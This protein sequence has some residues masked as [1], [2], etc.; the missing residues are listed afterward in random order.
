MASNP[1]M[2]LAPASKAPPR[3]LKFTQKGLAAIK[4]PSDPK[5]RLWV[6]DSEKPGLAFLVTGNGARSFYQYR[7]IHGKPTR[8]RLGGAELTI[9]QARGEVD[10]LN[11]EIIGGVDPME[12]RRQERTAGTIK[13]LWERYRDEHLKIRC[14]ARTLF[15][16]ENRYE[17]CLD[18]W[19]AR[20]VLDIAESDV[21]ALHARLGAERGHTTGNR[22]VQL[23]RR[24]FN[25]GR[26][27]NPAGK[28][29]VT[30]F[31]ERSRER[32]VQPDEL[33]RLFKALDDEQTNPLI[34]DFIY[35]AL[36]TGAR[37][38]AVASMRDEEINLP[39]RTWTIPPTKS[40]NADAVT[41]TL[42]PPAVEIIK[43]RMGDESGFILPS[44]GKSGHLE[45][46]KNTWTDVLNRAKLK[47]IHIH[48]LRRT[49]GSWQAG[50]GASLPII[51][52]SLGH[53]DVSATMIYSRLD[54]TPVRQSV[55]GA[56]A[57]MQ[58]TR[59]PGRKG[60]SK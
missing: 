36:W 34:R 9:E 41:I 50:L 13:E 15:T 4:P 22:A 29:A 45:D 27:T 59:K 8:I 56:V 28:S 55:D 51:G 19:G 2:R 57:A 20:K 46:P 42:A 7:R 3:K 18:E 14:S 5:A 40:K 6:W 58:A 35:L 17:T 33:P 24:M 26:L 44:R 54:L 39:A 31:R 25:W 43:R 52:R 38:S 11:G 23:L 60:K 48:D 1:L 30:M 12:K 21:R 10:R 47:D 37:R 32:F 49:L 16:D 53:R